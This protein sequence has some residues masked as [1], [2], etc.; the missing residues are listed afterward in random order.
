MSR[1]FTLLELLVAVF[2]SAV[3]FSLGYAALN[4]AVIQQ[5][6]L[7]NSQQSLADIQRAVRFMSQDVMQMMPRP[8]RDELGRTLEPTL[9]LD[10]RQNFLMTLSRGGQSIGLGESR[11]R[12]LRVRYLLEGGQ[13]IRLSTPILDRTA[14]SPPW[15]RRVLLDGVEG[16]QIRAMDSTGEWLESWPQQSVAPQSSAAQELAVLER[17]RSRPRAIELRLLTREFGEI[18]RVL[19][20]TG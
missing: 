6:R 2:I 16:L 17:L 9:V 20:V 8:V 4:Q 14:A 7:Q 10:P 5:D 15:R 18:R 12:L 19:E 11:G 3:M 13:L 1:G